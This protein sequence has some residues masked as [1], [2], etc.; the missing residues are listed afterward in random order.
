MGLPLAQK[1]SAVAP[2]SEAIRDRTLPLPN[3]KK[4][5]R[6]KRIDNAHKIRSCK[7]K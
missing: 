1:I 2:M 6:I 3:T 5:V 4:D 7:E